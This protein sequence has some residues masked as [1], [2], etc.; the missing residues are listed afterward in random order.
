MIDE[1]HPRPVGQ[2][3][4]DLHAVVMDLEGLAVG[5][6]AADQPLRTR[7]GEVAVAVV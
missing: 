5:I 4:M 2:A 6:D 3:A 1:E 7:H